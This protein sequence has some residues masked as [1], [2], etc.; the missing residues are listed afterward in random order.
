MNTSRPE[1]AG[2]SLP[3]ICDDS[4]SETTNPGLPDASAE[5]N[6]DPPVSYQ[7]ETN[8]ANTETD[9]SYPGVEAFPTV[10]INQTE[11]EYSTEP[12][13]K[14]FGVRGFLGLVFKLSAISH[15]NGGSGL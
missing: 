8:A 9:H 4:H 13:R 5:P 10:K 2:L 6:S 12:A 3:G 1:Q 14:P 15:G 7:V 11:I